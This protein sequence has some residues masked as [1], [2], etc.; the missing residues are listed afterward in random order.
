MESHAGCFLAILDAVV[1]SGVVFHLLFAGIAYG[2][3]LA[4][5]G[6][7]VAVAVAAAACLIFSWASTGWFFDEVRREAERNAPASDPHRTAFHSGE[8]RGLFDLSDDGLADG[9]D[10]G[11]E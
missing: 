10:A 6:H 11:G 8:A 9:G 1:V 7:E 3:A 2:A 4:V 5:T